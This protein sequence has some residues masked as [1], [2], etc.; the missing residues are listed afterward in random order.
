MEADISIWRKTGHFY[1]AL[2]TIEDWRGLTLLNHG[3][4]DCNLDSE[5]ADE[6]RVVLRASPAAKGIR[7]IG[8]Y[9]FDSA[10]S[11]ER[12]PEP[13]IMMTRAIAIAKMWYLKPS[14][15]WL[16]NQF[17]KEPKS[18]GAIGMRD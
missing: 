10:R 1:F 8:G 12:V 13:L 14:P 6:S 2:T 17:A 11:R 9:D 5:P 15:F 3:K 4:S 18:D 7:S 16:P